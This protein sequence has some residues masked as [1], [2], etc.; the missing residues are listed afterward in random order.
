MGITDW[1]AAEE[2]LKAL[3]G[4]QSR[5]DPYMVTRVI[6]PLRNRL[7]AGVRTVRLYNRI[8]DLDTQA[9]ME[10]TVIPR[11]FPKVRRPQEAAST[12]EPAVPQDTRA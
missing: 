9:L 6:I 4:E 10:G 2:K 1:K 5:L 3:M 8:M 11:R 7:Q 12:Q